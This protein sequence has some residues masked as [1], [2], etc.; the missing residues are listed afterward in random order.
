MTVAQ[1]D[2]GFISLREEDLD[3]ANFQIDRTVYVEKASSLIVSYLN[4]NTGAQLVQIYGLPLVG[5]TTLGKLICSH[6]QDSWNSNNTTPLY[7]L[8][9]FHDWYKDNYTASDHTGVIRDSLSSVEELESLLPSSKCLLFLDDFSLV[10]WL[11][12]LLRHQDICCVLTTE[13]FLELFR[14][15]HQVHKIKLSLLTAAES[16]GFMIK[17]LK[18]KEW[19]YTHRLTCIARR[20]NGFPKILSKVTEALYFGN[21]LLENV[22]KCSFSDL[23]EMFCSK[24][25]HFDITFRL[26]CQVERVDDVVPGVHIPTLSC[27]RGSFSTRDITA[28]SNLPMDVVT[29]K[30]LIEP[31]FKLGI[32]TRTDSESS[33][34]QFVINDI[35]RNLLEDRYN[36]LQNQ[37][38]LHS[39]FVAYFAK[40]FGDLE[41]KMMTDVDA[42]FQIFMGVYPNLLSLIKRA[43]YCLKEDYDILIEVGRQAELLIMSFL[44]VREVATFYEA[45]VQAAKDRG[46]MTDYAR[47]LS[48]YGHTLLVI[49]PDVE[50]AGEKL[51]EAMALMKK[52]PN[53]T[54]P[55][56]ALTTSHHGHYYYLRGNGKISI[57]YYKKALSIYEGCLQDLGNVQTDANASQFRFLQLSKVRMMNNIAI[58][59]GAL[60]QYDYSIKLHKENIRIHQEIF[61]SDLGIGKAY[62]CIGLMLHLKGDEEGALRYG[63]I[64]LEVKRRSHP[65]RP[66]LSIVYSM[67]HVGMS[68]F[69]LDKQRERALLMLEDALA[70]ID[71]LRENHPD[72]S[73]LLNGKGVIYVKSGDY[74]EAVNCLKEASRVRM[75]EFGIGANCCSGES[76][77]YLG[78]A[79][80]GLGDTAMAVQTFK[81]CLFFE[82]QYYL[83]E[84]PSDFERIVLETLEWLEKSLVENGEECIKVL[85]VKD[86]Q[87]KVKMVLNAPREKGDEILKAKTE[88][89]STMKEAYLVLGLTNMKLK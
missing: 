66:S 70:M 64:G 24:D 18:P 4:N 74:K 82:I 1:L 14:L 16:E 84:S 3:M 12:R 65:K 21:V 27:M 52:D 67:S 77:Q 62:H 72:R 73:L 43:I 29:N 41:E 10:K 89:K 42:F 53:I 13:V 51:R 60:R 38:V 30:S 32:V 86:F 56:I 34:Y 50:V 85:F 71:D 26:R 87:D 35:V 46:N 61:K 48:C 69:F 37:S 76:L 28:I 15:G 47:M 20:C 17:I 6:I 49:C 8:Q 83:E 36:F 9:V 75:K 19:T 88:L 79:Y 11:D 33:G 78:E 23:C 40:M 63:R 68:Y 54:K 5:K 57:K 58:S 81:K 22:Y 45:C 59:A 44:Q 25:E 55:E 7:V 2:K 31:M 80:F 39:R